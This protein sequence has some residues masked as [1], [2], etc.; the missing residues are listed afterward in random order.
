MDSLGGGRVPVGVAPSG[1]FSNVESIGGVESL[2]S[3]SVTATNVA[4]S[5]TVAQLPSHTHTQNAHGHT[6]RPQNWTVFN[7][8]PGG[9]FSYYGGQIPVSN[10]AATAT[11]QNTG[12][13]TAHN[14]TQNAHNHM[15]STLQPYITCYMFKRIR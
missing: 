4:M 15:N 3:E 8:T 9:N 13:G 14:H 1:T 5:L 6:N 2:L 10:N 11:N 12:S 7:I